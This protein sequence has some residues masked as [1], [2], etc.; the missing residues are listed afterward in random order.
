MAPS[1]FGTEH[2]EAA[3]DG[4]ANQQASLTIPEGDAIPEAL[5]LLIHGTY[6]PGNSSI[7]GTKY[8]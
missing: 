5:W 7:F 1:I 8:P 6:F 4:I 2:G 3:I